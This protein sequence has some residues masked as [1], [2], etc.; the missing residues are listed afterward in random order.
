MSEH[1]HKTDDVSPFFVAAAVETPIQTVLRA[2]LAYVHR[3]GA[4]EFTDETF[5]PLE[6]LSVCGFAVQDEAPSP[7]VR[8][9]AECV[10]DELE[11]GSGYEDDTLGL[12]YPD[13]LEAIMIY[14]DACDF[15][16]AHTCGVIEAAY[17]RVSSRC[18]AS[19][20]YEPPESLI[21]VLH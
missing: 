5:G 9:A 11:R 2:A 10:L 20:P 1:L 8:A 18:L 7:V 12:D 19:A 13:L 3:R 17:R 16:D 15:S 14:L 4:C 21:I 6:R